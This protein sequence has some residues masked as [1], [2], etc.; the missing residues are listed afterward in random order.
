[1]EEIVRQLKKKRDICKCGNREKKRKRICE[2]V[3]ENRE[4][5][6]FLKESRR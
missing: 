5:V 2:G 6:R 3:R 4:S 1:M